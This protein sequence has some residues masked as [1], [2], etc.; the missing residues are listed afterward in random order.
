MP[1]RDGFE[2]AEAV[3]QD[4]RLSLTRLLMLTSMGDTGDG[5]RC[6]ELGIEGYMNKPVAKV[7]LLE[8]AA[9]VLDR[10]R[11]ASTSRQLVTRHSIA[12]ARRRMRILLAEDNPVNQHVAAAMLRERG[13]EVDVVDNG[14]K[15]VDA[16]SGRPYDVVLMDIQ[17]PEMDGIAATAAI[18]AMP[19]RASTPIVA[20]TA[21]ALQSERE[22]C[23]SSGMDAYLSKPFNPAD[24]FA[25]VE[26]AR[27]AERAPVAPAESEPP[28]DLDTFRASLREAGIEDA[29]AEMIEVFLGDAPERMT[30]L[31]AAIRSGSAVD[32]AS[33][34]HAY[35]SAAATIGARGLAALLRDAEYA[36]KDGESRRAAELLDR[37][38]AEHT[39]VLEFLNRAA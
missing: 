18:R 16:I 3:R 13:H 2:L 32:I 25:A 26:G 19:E 20:M 31:E 38:Q 36:G 37:L 28:V 15:A 11:G 24:L 9:I 35:K 22:R 5:A 1:G 6:R 29:L 30:A 34:A 7:E 21:H 17:M 27:P 14:R 23:L 4:P 10:G 12:E 39:G 8:A 33:A